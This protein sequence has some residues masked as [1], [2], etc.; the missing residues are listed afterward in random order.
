MDGHYK[1]LQPIMKW[2]LFHDL[3]SPTNLTNFDCVFEFI[4]FAKLGK[5]YA[6]KINTCVLSHTHTRLSRN[7]Q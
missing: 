2:S 7:H 3:T 4:Y 1:Y 6:N 5:I